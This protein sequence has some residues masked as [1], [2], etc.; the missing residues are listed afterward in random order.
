M[1]GGKSRRIYQLELGPPVV[2]VYQLVIPSFCYLRNE[3]CVLTTGAALVW[4]SANAARATRQR[5]DASAS[6]ASKALSASAAA[7]GGDAG[8]ASG[9]GG[10][11]A[12]D[13]AGAAGGAG[14]ST[15]RRIG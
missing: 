11:R 7:A 4:F 13:A 14:A 6:K 15:E 5:L 9:G 1:G 10:A 8:S 3:A 12:A 2:R